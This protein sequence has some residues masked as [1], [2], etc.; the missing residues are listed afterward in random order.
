MLPCREVEQAGAAASKAL[1]AFRMFPSMLRD[2]VEVME[3]LKASLHGR[4]KK[5]AHELR[6]QEG[7]N[8]F[9]LGIEMFLKLSCLVSTRFSTF[10]EC[11]EPEKP[12]LCWTRSSVWRKQ[13]QSDN[14]CCRC[15]RHV[16]QLLVGRYKT[17]KCSCV[18]T[19]TLTPIKFAYVNAMQQAKTGQRFR[20]GNTMMV[21]RTLDIRIVSP[22]SFWLN[23]RRFRSLIG[24]LWLPSTNLESL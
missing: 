3:F 9:L 23:C 19:S 11:L 12:L 5:E 24:A 22:R 20:C 2:V 21:H 18:R 14:M 6:G 8:F 13:G 16:R 7:P 10:R 4:G 15:G 1:S 17:C